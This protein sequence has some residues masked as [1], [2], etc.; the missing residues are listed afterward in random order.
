MMI[1]GQRHQHL[2]QP[3]KTDT[4]SSMLENLSDFVLYS[5]LLRIQPDALSH[6]ERIIFHCLFLLNLKSM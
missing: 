6:K 1:S 2:C 5:K 3:D 4:Q